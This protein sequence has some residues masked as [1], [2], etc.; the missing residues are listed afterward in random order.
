MQAEFLNAIRMFER[1]RDTWTKCAEA[2]ASMKP[3][4]VGYAAYAREH[5]LMFDRMA[6][7]GRL[8]VRACGYSHI[9]ELPKD[10]PFYKHCE[11]VRAGKAPLYSESNGDSV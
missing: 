2:H 9:L 6:E 8:R 7:R 1:E 3:P 10:E 11:R 4:K 5:A